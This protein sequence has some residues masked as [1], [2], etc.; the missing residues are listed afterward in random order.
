VV[1]LAAI[2]SLPSA[3]SSM[4]FGLLPARPQGVPAFLICVVIDMRP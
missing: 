2:V 3:P 1:T 4:A